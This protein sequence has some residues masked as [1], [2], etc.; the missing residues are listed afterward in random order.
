MSQPDRKPHKP[1]VSKNNLNTY[2][3]FSSIALQMLVI[4]G[5]G[6]YIGLKL[7][8]YFPNHYNAYTIILTLV[9]VI[10]SMVYVIRR[11]IADSKDN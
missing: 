6:T 11:I 9:S 10:L 8:E 1:K 7:D 4:I 5:V 2:A 3:R